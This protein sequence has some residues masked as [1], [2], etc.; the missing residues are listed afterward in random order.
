[1]LQRATPVPPVPELPAAL[2]R[3]SADHVRM[4]SERVQHF[5]TERYGGF[6][7]DPAWGF[8]GGF[9]GNGVVVARQQPSQFLHALLL[10]GADHGPDGLAQHR[11]VEL[12]FLAT[13]D[14]DEAFRLEALRLVQRHHL[15][16]LPSELAGAAH[17]V[18]PGFGLR[19]AFA[20][21]K[22]HYSDCIGFDLI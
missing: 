14:R 10:D 12:V 8:H 3:D 22:Q 2:R 9:G 6:E 1:M 17:F 13:A 18:E 19:Q 5:L 16:G 7:H 11:S 20:V 21:L 15:P 4:T